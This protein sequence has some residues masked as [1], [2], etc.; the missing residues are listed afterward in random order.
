MAQKLVGALI[1]PQK[2]FKASQT[3]IPPHLHEFNLMRYP[4]LTEM[5]TDLLETIAWKSA[6]FI[7]LTKT[8]F[9]IEFLWNW[10]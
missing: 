9:L 3:I 8:Q 5:F 2:A 6:E 4:G 7:M 1:T 10:I